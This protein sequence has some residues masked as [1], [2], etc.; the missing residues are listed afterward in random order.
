MKNLATTFPG[1]SLHDPHISEKTTDSDNRREEVEQAEYNSETDL[2]DPMK[3]QWDS[4]FNFKDDGYNFDS[5]T[6]RTS[7][8]IPESPNYYGQLAPKEVMVSVNDEVIEPQPVRQR[9]NA[10]GHSGGIG[11]GGEEVVVCSS[12]AAYKRN[13]TLMRTKTKSRL[14]DQP[15]VDHRSPQNQGFNRKVLVI[16]KK[17]NSL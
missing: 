9:S 2:E 14:L 4:S 13:S 7:S 8:P 17:M 3:A 6:F 5:T 11:C 10:S 1:S 12:N 15:E 16:L